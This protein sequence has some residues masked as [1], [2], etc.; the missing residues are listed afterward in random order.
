MP[1]LRYLGENGS[2]KF[3]HVISKKTYYHHIEKADYNDQSFFMLS[4]KKMQLD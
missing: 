4:N 3:S 1:I 2:M